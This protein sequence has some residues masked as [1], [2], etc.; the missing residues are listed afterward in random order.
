MTPGKIHHAILAFLMTLSLHSAAQQVGQGNPSTFHAGS[1]FGP[2]LITA[3]EISAP[4]SAACSG[5]RTFRVGRPNMSWS[6]DYGGIG[7]YFS[8]PAGNG[9]QSFEL[10]YEI[11]NNSSEATYYPDQLQLWIDGELCTTCSIDVLDFGYTEGDLQRAH[12]RLLITHQAGYAWNTGGV[13]EFAVRYNMSES[14]VGAFDMRFKAVMEGTSFTE[15]LGT[16]VAPALPLFILRDP[17]GGSSFSSMSTSSSTCFGHSTSVSTSSDDSYW[18]KAKLGIAGEAGLFVTTEFEFYVEAGV[19]YSAAQTET[20]EFEYQ[21]CMQVTEE[22][23]TPPDGTPDDVFIGS[24]IRYKYGMATVVQRPS[25]GVIEKDAYFVAAP[26]STVLAYNYTESHIV[27]S[28]LPQLEL[29]ISQLPAG[30]QAQ[31]S[32][33]TQRDVWLQTLE[34]NNAIKSSAPLN[35]VRAFNGGGSSVSFTQETTSSSSMNI[36]YTVSLDEGLS[37]EFGVEIGGSGISGG[38]EMKMRREY[39]NAESSSNAVTNTMAYTLADDDVTDH[40]VVEVRKDPVFGTYAFRLDS[41]TSRTSCRYEGGYRIDQPQLSIGTPG[42]THSIVNEAPIGTAV[43]YPLILCNN[44]DIQR[45]YYLKFSAATNPN[46]AILSAFGNPINSN[47]NGAAV[48]LDPGQCITAN[49]QLAQPN[50]AVV[51]FSNINLYLYSICDEE[52][53]PYIRSYVTLSAHFGAGNFGSYCTPNTVNGTI[54]GDFVHGVQ[55]AGINNTNTGA[56]N[57]PT[58]TD[59]SGQFSTPLSRNAQHI[60][61]ITSGAYTQNQYAAWID[62]DQDGVFEVNEKL[63]AFTSSGSY[64]PTDIAFT[65]PASAVLGSTLLRV[66]ST[67]FGGNGDPNTLDPCLLTDYGETEDYAVVIN[68]NVPQ[69][70][71]GVNNG[72]ALPG[73]PCNDGN[74]LTGNDTWNA[75]C[76]CI[77]I[78]LDCAGTPGGSILPGSPCDDNDPN[79]GSDVY[80]SDCSCAGLSYDCVGIAGGPAVAGT[81]CNDGNPC[82]LD[83]LWSNSCI[84]IGTVPTAGTIIGAASVETGTAITL[85]VEPIAGASAYAWAL[86]EGWTSTDTTSAVLVAQ[87]GGGIGVC[88]GLCDRYGRRLRKEQLHR[89]GRGER[90]RC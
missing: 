62:Y 59:Y 78:A 72:T 31:R 56:I 51:D 16:Y 82:T 54:E 18:G 4:G 14:P 2:V 65:V 40:L 47:D 21:T 1:E 43:N 11:F 84:C 64:Q 61:T 30:S 88:G 26:D 37:Y 87:A 29:Q 42:N 85:E 76:N 19:S 73:T 49:L 9:N 75:N 58:Y 8:L 63:G 71:A 67:Y 69:D 35:V 41:A 90:N 70:C 32:A 68:T 15:V 86:P 38:G 17:P 34:M 25:C 81:S 20:A 79:T 77:G 89:G 39:G 10:E 52:Y 83:D 36:D 74:A 24:A 6:S 23:T 5:P 57:G 53:Q 80:G 22:F 3:F 13:H 7:T 33:V 50:A 28:V 27:E 12:G 60:I 44:S 48:T 45:T 66:R 46:G 55:L